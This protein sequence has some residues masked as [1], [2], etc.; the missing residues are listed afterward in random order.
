MWRLERSVEA[1]PLQFLEVQ[2]G[3]APHAFAISDLAG[4]RLVLLELLSDGFEDVVGLEVA[5]LRLIGELQRDPGLRDLS[6][7]HQF[8]RGRRAVGRQSRPGRDRSRALR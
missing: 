6:D 2:H 4:D 7:Q 1:L 3:V 8:D 5:P